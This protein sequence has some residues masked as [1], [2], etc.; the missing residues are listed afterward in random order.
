[1]RIIQKTSFPSIFC[2]LL[3]S[4]KKKQVVFELNMHAY[5]LCG[6]SFCVAFKKISPR[7][8]EIITGDFKFIYT[9]E[10]ENNE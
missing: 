8:E 4:A 9:S 1:M 7:Q 10:S 3:V 6:F 5:V 2:A